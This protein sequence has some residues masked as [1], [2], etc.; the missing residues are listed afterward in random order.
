M[1]ALIAAA[2]LAPEGISEYFPLNPGDSWVYTEVTDKF[3]LRTTDTVGEP[4][5]KDGNKLFPVV[6]SRDGKELDRVYYKVGEGEILIVAFK[7]DKPLLA[8][9][10]ILKSPDLGSKWTH[11][12]DTIMDGEL[13]DLT[14]EGQVKKAGSYEFKGK[15]V[16][17]IEVRLEATMMESFGTPYKVTQ[18]AVYGK[19]IGLLSMESTTKLPKRTV[20]MTRR[21]VEYRPKAN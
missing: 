7:L 8:P 17:T 9:Y 13:A 10:P 19:G 20:K 2:L 16:E 14:M 5:E 3:E 12:G 11:K 6:T 21:L 4:V 15:K 18:V 1:V